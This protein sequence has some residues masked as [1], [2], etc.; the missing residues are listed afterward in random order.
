MDS[1]LTKSEIHESLLQGRC[2]RL[3]HDKCCMT[4]ELSGSSVDLE[5]S[6]TLGTFATQTC[7]VARFASLQMTGKLECYLLGCSAMSQNGTL[8]IPRIRWLEMLCWIWF[9]WHLQD[10]SLCQTASIQHSSIDSWRWHWF[11]CLMFIHVCRNF[12]LVIRLLH[13]DINMLWL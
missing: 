9:D 4:S 7:L 3:N 5:S 12:H 2:F 6:R 1:N 8:Y 11:E 13:A 10:S